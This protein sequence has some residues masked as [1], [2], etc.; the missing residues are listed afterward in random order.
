LYSRANVSLLKHDGVLLFIIPATIKPCARSWPNSFEISIYNSPNRV[1]SLQQVAILA[2][3]RKRHDRLRDSALNEVTRYLE[4]LSI[5]D[6]LAE[7]ATR[8]KLPTRFPYPAC[9]PH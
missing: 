6:N 7:L 5:D 1:R 4:G 2:M 3:R 9:P 8:Q